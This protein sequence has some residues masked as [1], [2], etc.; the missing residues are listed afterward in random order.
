M[1][2]RAIARL[3]EDCRLVGQAC[4]AFSFN[5]GM[6]HAGNLAFLGMLALLPFL[7][8]LL[9]LSG[10]FGQTGAGRAAVD[11]LLASLP[12]RASE[13]IAAPL[14]SVVE[15]SGGGLLAFSVA[16]ALYTSVNGIEAARQAVIHASNG[17]EHA[18]NWWRR[19]VGDLALVLFGALAI[20]LATSL[21]VLLPAAIAAFE[22]IFALPA[23]IH[24]FSLAARYL[25]APLLL[26]VTLLGL[27]KA[28][29]PK[30]P[31]RRRR[32]LP[33]ALLTVAV[34]L[35]LG[36]G[37]AFYIRT[38]GRYDAIYGSLAGVVILMLFLFVSAAAFILGAHL[39]A[40]SA[41]RNGQGGD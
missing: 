16:F 1:T 37:L 31:G 40:A 22:R 6:E 17:R 4:R 28:F 15:A 2:I 41:A 32:Y 25:L 7:I 18:A 27:Y 20:T 5:H 11:F 34:W 12:P 23:G 36:E 19:I 29:T 39:N 21:I 33:G 14:H 35:V 8:F 30:L 24:D 3:G 9:S 26:L 10:L 38:F 13:A